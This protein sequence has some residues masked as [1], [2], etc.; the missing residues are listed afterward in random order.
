MALATWSTKPTSRASSSSCSI[1]SGLFSVGGSIVP[2]F[3]RIWGIVL[4]INRNVFDLFDIL[5][6]L[7][8]FRSMRFRDTI[9]CG[10]RYADFAS[11]LGT[12]LPSSLNRLTSRLR[13]FFAASRA[14]DVRACAHLPEQRSNA[15]TAS[16]SAASTNLL[17]HAIS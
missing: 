7:S 5:D 9:H 2:R 4:R 6:D 10:A 1:S 14:S 15:T 3:R 17:R 13:L 11:N 8:H 16:V 12:V